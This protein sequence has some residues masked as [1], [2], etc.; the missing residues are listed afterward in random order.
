MW[1]QLGFFADKDYLSLQSLPFSNPRGFS[2]RRIRCEGPIRLLAD[3]CK[4][5]KHRLRFI[6]P[7]DS[8]SSQF[9]SLKSHLS[10]SLSPRWLGSPQM[11]FTP[12]LCLRESKPN[13]SSVIRSRPRIFPES[14]I[15]AR[16]RTELYLLP[17]RIGISLSLIGNRIR[18]VTV[19]KKAISVAGKSHSYNA[20]YRLELRTDRNLKTANSKMKLH[21]SFSP[22]AGIESFFRTFD[23]SLRNNHY[24]S[25]F[26]RWKNPHCHRN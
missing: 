24:S 13:V 15:N 17:S 1:L 6:H 16:T 25:I 12:D 22:L 5:A 21:P 4:I 18:T 19:Q 20:E 11:F 10:S 3:V 14:C 2:N 8:L 23:R 26:S 9:L 7:N